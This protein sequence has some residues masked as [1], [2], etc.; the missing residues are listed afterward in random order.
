MPAE[1]QRSGDEPR[2]KTAWLGLSKTPTAPSPTAPSPL[3][4]DGRRRP[5][6][7][8]GGRCERREDCLDHARVLDDGDQAQAA[9]TA[10]AG[11]HVDLERPPHEIG[12]RPVTPPHGSRHLVPRTGDGTLH[13]K[14]YFSPAA[15]VDHAA[16]GTYCVLAPLRRQG[17]VPARLVQG[18][19]QVAGAAREAR[20]PAQHH[21]PQHPGRVE[22]RIPPGVILVWPPSDRLTDA[23]SL[24]Q[25]RHQRLASH[26]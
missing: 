26:Y 13:D 11:E 12:P 24:M 7:A 25:L 6:G 17:G 15:R 10:R 18:P 16:P 2:A 22:P 1:H 23:T 14:A 21:V 5:I 20:D 4:E 3:R 8:L 9:A 19:S